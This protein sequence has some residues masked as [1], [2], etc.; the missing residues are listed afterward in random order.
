MTVLA[1]IDRSRYTAAVCEYAA[2]A[3]RRL[4]VGVDLLH[5][6][7]WQP[8]EPGPI[9]RSGRMSLGMADTA[10]E[11][12]TRLNEARNRLAQEQARQLLDHAAHLIRAAGVGNIRER[13]VFGQLVDH[14]H[15][16]D[17]EARLIVVGRRGERE[18]QASSHLGSNLERIVRSSHHPVLIVPAEPR[19]LSRFLVAFDGSASSGKLIDLL[20]QEALL[21]EAECHLLMVGE[22]NELHRTQVTNAADALRSA[23]YAVEATIVPGHA[24]AVIIEK[25]RALDADLLMMGA[26]GHS[27]IR[28]MIIGSTTT[29]LLRSSPVPILV[30]R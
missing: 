19:K 23:G 28:E 5:A 7:D 12:F 6:I 20:T 1:C 10:L 3:A 2:R 18:D 25:V 26:Y 24:D 13:I 9:D 4:D 11:E 27:R 29:S 22:E 8:I 17:A 14:L 30:V 21:L 16:Y 15:D